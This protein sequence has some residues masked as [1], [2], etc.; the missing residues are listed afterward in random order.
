MSHSHRNPFIWTAFHLYGFFLTFLFFQISNCSAF[1]LWHTYLFHYILC[2]IYTI[3]Y[4]Q[5]SSRSPVAVCYVYN[6]VIVPS[7]IKSFSLLLPNW[8]NIPMCKKA[9]ECPCAECAFVCA[10]ARG[11]LVWRHGGHGT[12]GPHP[13]LR[14]AEQGGQCV[15]SVVQLQPPV[16]RGLPVTR[17]QPHVAPHR[18]LPPHRHK[19]SDSHRKGVFLSANFALWIYYTYNLL[20]YTVAE[21]ITYCI[22]INRQWR[23]QAICL[24][25]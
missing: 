22:F 6:E 14:E 5:I 19:W 21:N 11:V 23:R 7:N 15:Y 4:S 18:P 3:K 9:V 24:E 20:F 10:G 13:V 16:Q 25:Q 1:I 12:S 2:N 8:Q 17:G